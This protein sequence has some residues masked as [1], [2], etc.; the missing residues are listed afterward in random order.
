MYASNNQL[1]QLPENLFNLEKLAI[2]DLSNNCLKSLPENISGLIRLRILKLKGNKHL[3][4]LPKNICRAQI[5]ELLELDCDNFVYPPAEVVQRGTE[6]IIKYI[7]DGKHQFFIFQTFKTLIL[8]TG[9]IYDPCNFPREYPHFSTQNP[10]A[11]D[12]LQVGFTKTFS[13]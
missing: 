11:D 12:Q 9:Y 7:C 6:H 1:K 2:L 4:K 13:C 8:D 5:L 3:V 10:P